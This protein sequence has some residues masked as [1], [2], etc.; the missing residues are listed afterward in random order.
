[1]TTVLLVDGI[2][3]DISTYISTS[4]YQLI[5]HIGTKTNVHIAGMLTSL[6]S[7][8]IAGRDSLVGAPWHRS[9][10]RLGSGDG[11]HDLDFCALCWRD[12]GWL[13]THG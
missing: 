8:A 6:G 5:A 13:I 7:P 11:S 2:T 12:F 10:E 9:V 4:I 1:M 3:V